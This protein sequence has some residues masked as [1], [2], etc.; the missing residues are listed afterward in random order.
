MTTLPL[1]IA[2]DSPAAF[3][4]VDALD[5]DVL[6][7]VLA[8]LGVRWLGAAAQVSRR[9]CQHSRDAVLLR[10]VLHQVLTAHQW[11]V[12]EDQLLHLPLDSVLLLLR[13][14]P[15]STP[16]KRLDASRL[17]QQLNPNP[18][19]NPDP[20]PDPNPN[21]NLN[22]NQAAAAA[23]HLGGR[24]VR[25]VPRRAARWQPVRAR[26]R[27]TAR[28]TVP[29]AEAAVQCAA[30]PAGLSRPPARLSPLGLLQRGEQR[31]QRLPA[32]PSAHRRLPARARLL[33]RL[34]RG[35]HP[36]PS[37]RPRHS[38]ARLRGQLHRG[39]RLHLA[40]RVR[41]QAAGLGGGVVLA[42][43][44]SPLTTHCS[45]LTILTTHCSLL[46]AHYSLLTTH[47]SL[48]NAQCSPRTTHYNRQPGWDSESYGYHGDDGRLFHGSGTQVNP[49]ANLNPNPNP[50]PNPV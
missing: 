15:D 33:H 14:Q 27:A 6:S 19:P 44:Y 24:R 26:L 28:L 50:N 42:T 23:Q 46:T 18:N 4:L 48:L 45:L 3:S 11:H 13:Q 16:L 36:E 39:G 37:L 25:T 49:N 21:P 40:L 43:C 32:L 5:D 12:R 8:S 35:L 34:L 17:P 10:K 30:L 38:R 9:T 29:C 41:R 47:C 20:N 31:R 1:V 22:P 7:L 2:T